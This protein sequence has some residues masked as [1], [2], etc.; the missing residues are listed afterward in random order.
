MRG[1]GNMGSSDSGGSGCT[2]GSI[3]DEMGGMV[4][5]CVM[6]GEAYGQNHDRHQRGAKQTARNL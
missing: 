2:S 4:G 6:S 5:G 3:G 1:M